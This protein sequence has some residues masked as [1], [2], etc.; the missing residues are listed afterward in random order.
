[1]FDSLVHV[2]DLRYY[3]EKTSPEIVQEVLDCFV[4]ELD[5]SRDNKGADIIEPMSLTDDGRVKA[6]NDEKK[7]R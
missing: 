2:K 7:R 6:T 1:M 5:D 4:R 3:A